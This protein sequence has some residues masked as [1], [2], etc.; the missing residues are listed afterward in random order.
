L[1]LKDFAAHLSKF[2]GTLVRR[3]TPVEKQCSTFSLVEIAYLPIFNIFA[4]FN[5]KKLSLFECIILAK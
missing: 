4:F 5:R 3:G 2:G 1:T